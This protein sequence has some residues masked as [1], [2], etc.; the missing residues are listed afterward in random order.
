MLDIALLRQEIDRHARP[1]QAGTSVLAHRLL[2]GE[3]LGAGEAALLDR[4]DAQ[5]QTGMRYAV[6]GRARYGAGRYAAVRTR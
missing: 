5:T 3:G 6:Y 4:Y 1:G 2:G